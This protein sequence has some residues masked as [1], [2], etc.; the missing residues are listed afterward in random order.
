MFLRSRAFYLNSMSL[1]ETHYLYP[2]TLYTSRNP[3]EVTTI[4]GS[5]VA[6][7]LYDPVSRIGGINHYMLPV[8]GGEGLA[9]PKYGDIAI[10]KLLQKMLL[11]GAKKP[12][13]QAKV[14][15]GADSRRDTN[16]FKIGER[17]CQL[18][19]MVLEELTIPV[20]SSHLGGELPRKLIFR[21]GTGEALLKVLSKEGIPSQ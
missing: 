9:S 18:A 6:V 8:W 15:G 12:N 10:D 2:S 20:I 4:L 17:N 19:I 3:T 5:C 11:F 16:V 7:C 14:F 1:P 13:L 21:T